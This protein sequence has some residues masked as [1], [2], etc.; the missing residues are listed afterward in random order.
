MN[1]VI[2]TALAMNNYNSTEDRITPVNKGENEQN[3]DY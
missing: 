3:Y 1:R 2:S